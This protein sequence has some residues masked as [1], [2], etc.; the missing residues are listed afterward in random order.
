MTIEGERVFFERSKEE[1]IS[2]TTLSIFQKI[3]YEYYSTHRRSFPWREVID[4]YRVFISEVMLQQTQAGPRTIKKFDEFIDIFP[5]FYL[6]ASASLRDVLKVW[7]GLGYNR[8]ALALK[9][10]A[11][12][13][14]ERYQG[15]LPQDRELLDELPGIGPATASSIAA[16]AFNKP[17]IFIET[18]IRSV[19]I[20]FFFNNEREVSDE[21]IRTLVEK[22]LDRN[23]PREWYYALMDYGAML[24]KREK[25]PSRKS[26]HYSKQSVFEG[27]T[28]QLRGKILA[29]FTERNEMSV[30]ELS[31]FFISDK[32]RVFT[33]LE[34]LEREGFLINQNN[35]IRLA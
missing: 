28:R 12:I 6:L 23:S 16:F 27:S 31:A 19:F 22:T 25:N 10:A 24:K 15:I 29:L 5:N 26:K 3:I 35:L 32:D 20:H 2:D 8:R 33:L 13:V 34:D 9:K 14:I 11:E 4:P 1:S 21:L 18:N 17:E 30:D 7:Q